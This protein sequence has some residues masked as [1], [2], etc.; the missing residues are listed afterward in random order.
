VDINS[1]SAEELQEIIHIGEERAQASIE[2][3][4][5]DSVDDLTR[6]SGIA[7]GRLADI[8]EQGVACVA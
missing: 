1:A 7:A 8:K 2:Q 6:I 3:R 5:F 4:P